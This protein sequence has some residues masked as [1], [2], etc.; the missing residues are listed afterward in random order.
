MGDFISNSNFIKFA[1]EN[2]EIIICAVII[3]FLTFNTFRKIKYLD[4]VYDV[5]KPIYSSVS[6][7]IA[8]FLLICFYGKIGDLLNV[9]LN[10]LDRA[11]LISNGYIHSLFLALVFCTIK[12]TFHAIF[13]AFNDCS[14]VNMF[15]NIKN[16]KF[17]SFIYSLIIGSARGFIFI[18]L[19]Y[20]ITALSNIAFSSGSQY[21]FLNDFKL[22]NK[23]YNMLIEND[24]KS[25]GNGLSVSNSLKEKIQ[26][27]VKL[28]EKIVYYNGV[29]INEGI[30]SNSDIKVKAE[31]ITKRA[32]NDMEKAKKLYVWVGSN[33]KYDYKKAQD[34]V[35]G[36]ENIESG[37][38]VTF[39]S[40]KGIC[41][42]YAC[43]Y[44]AMAKDVG[45]K[46][47]VVLGEAY[48][49]KEFISHS[50]NEVYI[51]DEA[52]W[53][54]LDCTFYS[55]GNYFDNDD[56]SKDHINSEVIGEF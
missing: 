5:L 11:D 2:K 52:R 29:T 14:L 17:K 33:I 25:I 1:F 41:F 26:N 7:I 47:R 16:G 36:S 6:T 34:V 45:L 35:V 38:I 54:K 50:W 9:T 48:N 27:S 3:I 21:A 4:D 37:A 56:F 31:E 10:Y 22:Y 18:I 28:N 24:I 49:G 15:Y 51:E 13:R 40:R 39:N 32:K 8:I 42:D 46:T 23:V 30:K 53:V 19:V 43:L 12:L 55:G 20:L 44:T